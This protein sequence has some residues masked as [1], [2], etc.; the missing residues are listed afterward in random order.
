MIDPSST[1]AFVLSEVE[2]RLRDSWDTPFDCAQ[3][4]WVWASE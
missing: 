2:G 4:E 1:Y 3:D